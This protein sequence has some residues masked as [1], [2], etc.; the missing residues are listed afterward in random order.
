[1]KK[2]IIYL[3]LLVMVMLTSCG[4]VDGQVIRYQIN[5]ENP[6]KSYIAEII[7]GKVDDKDKTSLV[8]TSTKKN[9]Q[10][11]MIGSR[12]GILQHFVMS[13]Q[14][15]KNIEQWRVVN[16][17]EIVSWVLTYPEKRESPLGEELKQICIDYIKNAGFNADT[18]YTPSYKLRI[19]NN[20]KFQESCDIDKILKKDKDIPQGKVCGTTYFYGVSDFYQ[21]K[22]DNGVIQYVDGVMGELKS[23][24][25]N[26]HNIPLVYTY[27]ESFTDKKIYLKPDFYSEPKSVEE[28]NEMLSEYGL[29]LELTGK[30]MMVVTFS[31]KDKPA[32]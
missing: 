16:S 21:K 11:V 31:L 30:E 23:D 27:D 9:D 10:F 2:S 22:Y 7:Q 3:A 29:S 25:R 26:F 15:D 6:S 8:F 20:E 4:S 19:V 5:A 32:K 28:V 1:M 18:I 13:P 12:T 17:D 14:Y 24:L